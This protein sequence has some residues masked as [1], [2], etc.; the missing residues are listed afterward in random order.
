MD[1]DYCRLNIGAYSMHFV[2]YQPD[3]SAEKEFCEDIPRTGRTIVVL[4]FVDMELR[5]LPTEVRIVRD[6][7]AQ[8][9][10][11]AVTV[12]YVPP[13]VY[14]NG[15]VHFEHTFTEPGKFVGLVSVGDQGKLVARFPFSVSRGGVV[16]K[17]AVWVLL[18]LA[19]G[20]GLYFYTTRIRPRLG[21]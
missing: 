18:A 5:A 3:S 17:V 12:L 21:G 7:G 10:L 1:D 9:N 14:P 13:K 16:G 4:D 2:G 11:D 6:T 15:S 19:I 20:G 8:E